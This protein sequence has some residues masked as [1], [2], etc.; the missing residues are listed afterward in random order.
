MRAH[1]LNHPL[2]LM[3]IDIDHFKQVN[4]KYGHQTGDA[5]LKQVAMAIKEQMRLQVDI[6]ARYGGEEIAVIMPEVNGG[7][8]SAATIADRV[9]VALEAKTFPVGGL[10]IHI[11][12]SIGVATYPAQASDVANLIRTADLALYRAKDNGRNRVEVA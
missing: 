2:S 9:R 11:T 7:D 1:R 6:V 4:D 3:I 10:N 8:P 5:I 12:V